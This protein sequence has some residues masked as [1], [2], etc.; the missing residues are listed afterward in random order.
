MMSACLSERKA[1]HLVL[2]VLWYLREV[3]GW[4]SYNA[5]RLGCLWNK[6]RHYQL[7]VMRTN[8][9]CVTQHVTLN[10]TMTIEHLIIPTPT[11]FCIDEQC[12]I[13]H[14]YLRLHMWRTH[15]MDEWGKNSV[16]CR[17]T[18]QCVESGTSGT[19]KRSMPLY[20]TT[21]NRVL[22]WERQHTTQPFFT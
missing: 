20:V 6:H 10:I 17:I 13:T 15:S 2:F 22:H 1:D 8:T 4:R 11:I 21:D 9:C 3:S 19:G 16:L 5:I 18:R 12:H 14:T 7:W